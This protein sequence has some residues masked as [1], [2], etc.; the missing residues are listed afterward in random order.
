[1]GTAPWLPEPGECLDNAPRDAQS[2]ILGCSARSCDL[3]QDILILPHLI[4]ALMLEPSLERAA[5]KAQG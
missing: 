5:D 1:M 2:G 3:A 4:P